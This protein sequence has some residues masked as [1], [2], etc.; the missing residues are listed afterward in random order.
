[1]IVTLDDLSIALEKAPMG[2]LVLKNNRIAWLNEVLTDVAKRPKGELI[3]RPLQETPLASLPN[4]S[5]AEIPI[6][7]K[8]RW[9]EHRHTHILEGSEIHYF[10]DV[11]EH[12]ELREKVEQLQQRV[13]SLETTDPVTGLQNRRSILQELDRQISRSR[14][15]QNPLSL[16]RLSINSESS[17][18]RLHSLLKTISQTLKDKLRWADEIG[19]LDEHTFLLILPET[20]LEDAKE[21]AVK[22][23]SDRATFDFKEG[24][25]S[26][27]YGVAAW[28]KGD[29]LNKLLRRVEKDQEINLSALL[30]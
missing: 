15:Y 19:M 24:E 28:Q 2:V 13:Y 16:I 21:L 8:V 26:I 12:I 17:G 14:R 11:T 9:L 5:L 3:G 18:P 29:D 23:L 27:R 4:H 22:L 1:M 20:S 7:D 10:L 25:S 30:S 6:D